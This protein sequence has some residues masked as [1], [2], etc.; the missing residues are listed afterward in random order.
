[1]FDHHLAWQCWWP[2][3][4][5]LWP[6]QHNKFRWIAFPEAGHGQ[7]F[8]FTTT[9]NCRGGQQALNS[10]AA[11]N[12]TQETSSFGRHIESI[13]HHRFGMFLRQMPFLTQPS[14][15]NQAWL[16]LPSDWALTL[17]PRDNFAS[18]INLTSM[19]L[20]GGRKPE[21]PENMLSPHRKAPAGN[22]TMNPLAANHRA[23]KC[24][25]N[26]GC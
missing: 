1:M 3:M 17:A 5:S 6:L 14:P 22:R 10:S 24:D 13:S 8:V 26:K 7:R 11:L 12:V 4:V 21:Y 9:Y 20:G 15:F 25:M 23:A 19:F 2:L 18:L 16:V